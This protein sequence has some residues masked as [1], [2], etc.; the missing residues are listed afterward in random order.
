M[1][2][3]SSIREHAFKHDGLNESAK[4]GQTLMTVALRNAGIGGISKINGYMPN[5]DGGMF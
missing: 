5:H 2:R 4:C 1:K 3:S